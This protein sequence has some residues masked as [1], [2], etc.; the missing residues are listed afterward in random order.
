MPKPLEN[1]HLDVFRAIADAN[2]RRIL[3]LLL[4]EE[5]A[6][7]ELASHMDVTMGAVSQ[8]LKILR[9]CGLVTRE[10][11]GRHRYYRIHPQQLRDVYEWTRKYR[12]FWRSRLENLG[13]YL[14]DNS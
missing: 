9:E 5:H 11:R 12:Q 6:V 7:Q 14:D 2:R 1:K 4:E 3:D 10:K 8:H 13:E